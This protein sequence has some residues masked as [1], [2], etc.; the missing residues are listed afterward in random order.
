MVY[1]FNAG[2][3]LIPT[4]I[5]FNQRFLEANV[6]TWTGQAYPTTQLARRFLVRTGWIAANTA[7]R[8]GGPVAIGYWIYNR[9]AGGDEA[10]V[11]D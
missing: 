2:F 5:W 3:N 9:L 11:P 1:I 10:L 8:L 7:V 4:S 6:A